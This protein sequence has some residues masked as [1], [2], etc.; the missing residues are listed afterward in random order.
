MEKE[1]L[2]V[3]EGKQTWFDL[4]ADVQYVCIEDIYSSLIQS[5]SWPDTF[6]AS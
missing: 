6:S 3:P 4:S 2:R 1:S 5:F